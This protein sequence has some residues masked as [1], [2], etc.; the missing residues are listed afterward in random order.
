MNKFLLYLL[1]LNL[2]FAILYIFIPIGYG[3]LVIINILGWFVATMKTIES[4]E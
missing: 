4:K 1:L 3:T 2:I